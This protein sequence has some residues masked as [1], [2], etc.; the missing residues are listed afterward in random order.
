MVK[1]A[2]IFGLLLGIVNTSLAQLL[3]FNIDPNQSN[4]VLA[5][6]FSNSSNT[7]VTTDIYPGSMTSGISGS[8]D[9]SVDFNQGTISFDGNGQVVVANDNPQTPV[10]PLGGSVAV[11]GVTNFGNGDEF[12]QAWRNVS[13]ILSSPSPIQ[14]VGGGPYSFSSLVQLDG[15][16]QGLQY[17]ITPS[18]PGSET[19]NWGTVNGEQSV[20]V[21]NASLFQ[22][23]PVHWELYLPLTFDETTPFNLDLFGNTNLQNTAQGVFNIVAIASVP[24]VPSAWLL[25]VFVIVGMA[26][27][28][29]YRSIYRPLPD[30]RQ[31]S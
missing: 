24:E 9:A 4:F 29:V 27:R 25:A 6:Q 19:P 21:T 2:V 20:T 22:I 7:F 1:H 3:T 10:Y 14:M 16:R 23:D 12:V 17:G 13:G 26:F 31:M 30:D 28:S 18:T 8:F 5:Q 15:S 11:V